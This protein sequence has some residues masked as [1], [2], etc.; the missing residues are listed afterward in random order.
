MI[1]PDKTYTE[2]PFVDNIIYYAKFIGMNCAIKD[3]DEAIANETKESLEAA[4]TYIACIE[5]NATYE[6]F[7]KIPKEI[8]QNYITPASNLDIYAKDPKWLEIRLQAIAE[9]ERTKI[10]NRLS[11]LART[12]YIDHFDIITKYI[13]DVG[14]TWVDDNKALYEA[15]KAGTATYIDLFDVLPMKTCLRICRSYL[16]S[17]GYLDLAA[18]WD[19]NS[20]LTKLDLAAL[21]KSIKI[22]GGQTNYDDSVK[23]L[24]LD[25]DYVSSVSGYSTDNS[26]YK[27][28]FL[29]YI[30]I[31]EDD[32]II[33]ELSKISK[34]M[35]EVFISH[36]ETMID[37]G[38]F[39]EGIETKGQTEDD[40][41]NTVYIPA[42][43]GYI[44][45]AD[46]Y[47]KCQNGKA[48]WIDL[49]PTFPSYDIQNIL[50]DLIG[51]TTI[52]EYGLDNLS[53]LIS[54]INDYAEDGPTL[55]KSLTEQMTSTYLSNY[56]FYLNRTMYM[57]C[58]AGIINIYQLY[59]Y[60]PLET[61]KSIINTEFPQT[62]NIQVY[63]N[64]KQMLNS[65]LGSI[66]LEQSTPIKEAIAKDMMVWYPP[67]HV[68]K[69][70]YY[71]AYLGLPPID[72]K[73]NVYEDTL[74]HTYDDKSRSYI[75][76]SDTYT[77]MCPTD[78]YPEG[79][80]KNELY[81]YDSY[82]IATLRELGI[83][84]AYIQACQSLANTSGSRYKYLYYLGNEAFDLYT[85]RKADNFEL[86]GLPTID[87]N[88]IRTKFVDAFEVNREY[89][90]R[91]V[92]A[93]CYKFESD[94]Y[95]KFI[96][97]FLLINT[98]MDLVTSIPDYIINKT[99]FDARCIRYLFESYGVPYY[100]EIPLKYQKAI[101]KNLHILLKYKSSTKNMIDICNL[102][103]FS[104]VKVFG[105]YLMKSRNTD[106]TGNYIPEE[107]NDIH[108][109]PENIYVKYGGGEV[110]D[111]TGRHF[112]KLADYPY[113]DKDYY[114]K[115]VTILQ[116]DGSTVEKQIINNDRE[117]FVYDSAL[118]Q[119]IPLKDSTYFTKVKAST[120]PAELKFIKV[121][122]GEQITE[123]KN[124]EDYIMEYDEITEE[125]TWDG[126]IKH[127]SLKQ[128]ILDYAFNAVK[129]KYI[130]IDSVTNLTE[131]AFQTSYF[132]NMLFDNVYAENLLTL[133]V[134]YLQTGHL[135]RLTDI[136]FFLF[137][138]TY[139]YSGVK[140]KIMYSPTQIL[141]VKGYSFSEA[142]S[143]VMNDTRYFAP[144][145]SDSSKLEDCFDINTEI[146]KRNYNYIETFNN[147]KMRVKGFNL[148]ADIDAL[149]KWLNDEWQMSLEDFVVSTDTDT[150]GQIVTLK[151]FYSLNNSYYQKDIFSG[152]M[153]PSQYNNIIK[154]AYD[155]S[156]I[157]KVEINDIA[158]IPHVYL[159]ETVID[160]TSEDIYSFVL[161]IVAAVAKSNKA[162]TYDELLDK[163]QQVS[164]YEQLSDYAYLLDNI[165]AV[166]D[167]SEYDTIMKSMTQ[168]F[169]NL[170]LEPEDTSTI[171]VLNSTKY[172]AVTN[173]TK[174][175]TTPLYN[176]YIK[177][178]ND[179]VLANKQYYIYSSDGEYLPLI[180]GLIYIK[181]LEG[182]LTFG[183]NQIF[184]K[185][186]DGEML[187]ID[188]D[189]YTHYDE[190]LNAK[191]LN[192]GNY[193]IKDENGLW[194]LD[195]ENCY[196]LARIDG[197]WQYI[198]L[199]DT[200]NY[201]DN[202]I[203]KED[204]FVQTD[205]G[206][207]IQFVYTDYYIRTHNDN[208]VTNEMEYHEISLYVEVD[209]ET[210]IYDASLPEAS[211]VYY[212][213]LKD[214]YAEDGFA[215]SKN[216]LY[217][218]N[219]DGEYIPEYS[220]LTPTNTWYYDSLLGEYLLVVDSQYDYLDYE[221][222]LNVLY[223]MVL[224]G[225]YDYYK[226]ALEAS[227][228]TY[229]F[230]ETAGKRYVYNSDNSKITV[231]DT[232]TTY[233][234]TSKLIVVFN[235]AFLE[236][237]ELSDDIGYNPSLKDGVWDE[238]DWYYD[239]TG[240][241]ADNTISM[242]GENIWYYIKPGSEIVSDDN[243]EY[244]AK[245]VMGSGY[246]INASEYIGSVDLEE[247]EEYYLSLDITANFS[248]IIRVY[249]TA[250]DSISLVVDRNYT[251]EEGFILHIDQTF[252]A[253]STTR[254]QLRIE[255]YDFNNNPIY[256]G[257]YVV[258]SNLR[259]MKA[260][261]E[262][263]IPEDIASMSQLLSIY[264][265]NK[266][267]YKWLLTQMHNTNDKDMY[268]IYQTLYDALMITDYNKEIFKLSD[269]TYALTYTDFLQT[270]D[271][272]LYNILIELQNMDTEVMQK[273]ISDYIIECCYALTEQFLDED[274]QYLYNYFPGVSV[275]YIQSYLFKV[276]NWFKSWKVHLLG[277]NTLY[278]M[279]NGTITDE[280]GNVLAE[281][282]GDEFTV[283]ILHKREPSNKMGVYQKD[284]FIK[285]TIQ[286][287]PLDGISP[288]GT[289][290]AEKY[291]FS[292]NHM[293]FD[294]H[295]PL[296]HRIRMIIRYGNTIEY[297]DNESNMHL[298]LNDDSSI[299][300]VKDGTKLMVK[301]IN[302]DE[303]ETVDQNK[304]VIHTNESPEDV[305]ASQIIDEIN[306]LS[307]DYIS[308]QEEDDEDDE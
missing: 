22:S 48:T 141:T 52:T 290:Y 194:I 233:E 169:Y 266:A 246:L 137:A 152:L 129:S 19:P 145:S 251:I 263:Y 5:G 157:S 201:V 99:V 227:T 3:M 200:E 229:K 26:N 252:I 179:Y 11:S 100:S 261:S 115:T 222:P 262:H 40:A 226:Y 96:I 9:P 117:L 281:V 83:I 74:V 294:E 93:D 130:S 76:F 232:S 109:D 186:S 82:D 181:N 143:A 54:Y 306:L 55:D 178:G 91:C 50:I 43:M 195:P 205:D 107:D 36:Y 121:P 307:G 134:N 64:S 182:I 230:I 293:R 120:K 256:V 42:W 10:L 240:S 259:I 170:I 27:N 255:R 110:V 39:K 188:Y 191:I 180:D 172:G 56:Q 202:Y 217:V 244:S 136:I 13:E 41:G 60:L 236:D 234:D 86:M 189:K 286:I 206:H 31:R 37:R 153:T 220:L 90:I 285:D 12:V 257:N 214:F 216:V 270:R 304:L 16:N 245:T 35:R 8:L 70:N 81:K 104:D 146:A 51:E 135:F 292:D 34:A 119:M 78:I 223:L 149:E 297:R 299:V 196:V 193:F 210:S 151:Q 283:K 18:L 238:N 198:L 254:P 184:T 15:C 284:G 29:A 204:C 79:H 295:I 282:D 280:N 59:D 133:K 7:S 247:G 212:K 235:L 73:G 140:D 14:P 175:K 154:Y 168:D 287:N 197:E 274:L 88:D 215:I 116:D 258:I 242:H 126:G 173:G 213:K 17:H 192:L 277:I 161:G 33:T 264:R 30:N 224:H 102:F 190:E 302:G 243:D 249:C 58:K 24:L 171:F 138:L 111:I 289:P 112:C 63:A 228:E 132:Y 291:D 159:P 6:M 103:G 150:Y 65:F 308:P 183:A 260:Y 271:S 211:R 20:P 203:D 237:V 106:S 147:V 219:E 123:Y 46:L 207:F 44:F 85:M 241:D 67:N 300:S 114:M 128:R 142:V 71:R 92:Y 166:E 231:L 301:T 57:R 148:K 66:P 199:K 267:I 218:K 209:Y 98:I 221:E 176:K 269:G 127:E 38:Y 84:D 32:A 275:S 2:N 165:F 273:A 298:I 208:P 155:F 248:G 276:I 139:Y 77:S 23:T 225:N 305:F 21:E 1:I 4:T 53:S 156:E 278:R 187:D 174:Y 158:H 89:I 94:Y 95:N 75:E 296:R 131:I 68:E 125:E 265:T 25:T 49:Y 61:R 101:L 303:F 69:N 118:E 160:T 185:N 162:K 113:F 250:D 164:S 144:S 108:Y 288:D 45:D 28:Q 177:S 62:S 279:G 167:E 253:N 268:T 87:D 47:K 72:S 105:Y 272:I 124:D 122:I 239:G 163:I 97:L 80:W